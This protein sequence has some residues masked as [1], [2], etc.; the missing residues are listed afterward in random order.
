L[1][2]SELCVRAAKAD[3]GDTWGLLGE[4]ACLPPPLPKKRDA[5]LQ[6]L[7]RFAANFRLPSSMGAVRA[8]PC[9]D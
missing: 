8:L 3:D 9:C 1:Q 7:R 2:V 5:V 4:D 6:P